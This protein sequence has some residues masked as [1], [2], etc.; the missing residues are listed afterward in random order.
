MSNFYSVPGAWT[1]TQ[2]SGNFAGGSPDDYDPNKPAAELPA[3]A[4][5]RADLTEA[6]IAQAGRAKPI[7]I[8]VFGQTG[9]GKTSFIKA[10]SGQNLEVGHSLTSCKKQP[11]G[12]A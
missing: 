6:N 2:V 5:P 1:D 11:F 8:A 4:V 12:F 7:I 3:Q 9:T 10:V